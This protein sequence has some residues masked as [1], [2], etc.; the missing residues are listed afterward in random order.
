MAIALLVP[1]HSGVGRRTARLV[2]V[3]SATGSKAH[4]ALY[5][6][7]YRIASERAPI[8]GPGLVARIACSACWVQPVTTLPSHGWTTGPPPAPPGSPPTGVPPGLEPPGPS[9]EP[10]P[11]AASAPLKAVPVPSFKNVRRFIAPST[12]CFY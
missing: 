7:L 10:W 8:G 9:S 2:G 12:V 4:Q 6:Q 3:G 1:V 11:H 5:M